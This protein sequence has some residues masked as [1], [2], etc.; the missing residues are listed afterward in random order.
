MF[1]RSMILALGI[2]SAA[3]GCVGADA[4]EDP[5]SSDTSTETSAVLGGFSCVNGVSV[6]C[7]GNILVPID[8]NIKDVRVL[9]NNELNVLSNDLNKVSILDGGILNND[10]ILNDVQLTVL[11]DFLNKFNIDV[12]KNDI[13]VCATV[14][15]ALICK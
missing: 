10:K 2:G 14:L 15:G 4:A 8:I 12:T 7:T 3:V 1:I 6:L 9:D 11:Q 13:D 5:N